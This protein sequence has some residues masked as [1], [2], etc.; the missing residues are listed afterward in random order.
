MKPLFMIF[1]LMV[2]FSCQEQQLNALNVANSQLPPSSMF[3]FGR[4]SIPC[5]RPRIF[6]NPHQP[7]VLVAYIGREVSGWDVAKGRQAFHWNTDRLGLHEINDGY[8][9]G[10]GNQILLAGWSGISQVSLIDGKEIASYDKSIGVRNLSYYSV[11][12]RDDG[13]L[14]AA[15]AITT[16]PHYIPSP[17]GLGVSSEALENALKE[18]PQ[19]LLLFDLKNKKELSAIEFKDSFIRSIQFSKNHKFVVTTSYLRVKFWDVTDP[20]HIKLESEINI[21]DLEPNSGD[22]NVFVSV[23]VSMDLRLAV[24]ATLRGIYVVNSETRLVIPSLRW[25]Q[26]AGIPMLRYVQW[27]ASG[28]EIMGSDLQ[29]R[30]YLWSIN[31]SENKLNYFGYYSLGGNSGGNGGIVM[32]SSTR[33]PYPAFAIDPFRRYFVRPGPAKSEGFGSCTGFEVM[34]LPEQARL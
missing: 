29:G 27:S 13:A 34:R 28:Q 2:F 16:W 31:Q 1:T 10:D 8:T 11:V 18:Q 23:A 9:L 14:G 5:A 24:V 22:G 33:T 30:V 17:S 7:S 3:A 6:I 32:T 4:S 12:A 21:Q 20:L 15:S 19:K 25:G 26:P